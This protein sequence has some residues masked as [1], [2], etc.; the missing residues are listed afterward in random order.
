MATEAQGWFYALFSMNT[1]QKTLKF[2]SFE[3][4]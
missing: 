4:Q 2:G 3:S 1:L